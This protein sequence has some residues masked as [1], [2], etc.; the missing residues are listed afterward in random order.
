MN[1]ASPGAGGRTELFQVDLRGVVEILSQ[2]LYSSPRVFLRELLQ[3]ARDAVVARGAADAPGLIQVSVEDGAIVVADNGIGLDAGEM[4]ALL[5]TIGA[6][7]KRADLERAQQDFLGR[8]GIGLLSCFLI[9]DAVEVISRSAKTDHA[10]TVRWVGSSDG[11]YEITEAPEALREPGSRIIVRPRPEERAWATPRRLV[12]VARE[13]ARYL[14]TPVDVVDAAGVPVRVSTATAP[15]DLDA[16]TRARLC[17]ET[18][19]FDPLTTVRIDVPLLGVRG[20]AFVTP[21]ETA[22]ARRGGDVVHARGMLVAD[23]NTQ[24]APDWAYFARLIVD[25]GTL[26]L[27]ASR[28]SLQ[29]T[30]LVREA[31]AAVGEQIQR[32]VEE[33]ARSHPDTFRRFVEAHA[34][35]LRAMALTD[36]TMFAFMYDHLRFGTSRGERTLRQLVAGTDT[37]PPARVLHPV[38]FAPQFRALA[39]L[40]RHHDLVLIDACHVHEPQL[41]AA[42]DQSDVDVSVR[43][44]DL[45]AF[46][47]AAAPAADPGLVASIERLVASALPGH[48]AQVVDLGVESVAALELA[49]DDAWHPDSAASSGWGSV[50]GGIAARWEPA[51]PRL[52]LNVASPAVRALGGALPDD[53]AAHAVRALSVLGRLHTGQALSDDD[54]LLLGDSLSTLITA[55]TSTDVAGGRP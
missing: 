46:V 45:E 17:V 5:A 37:E 15:Q 34:V 16:E 3:N 11:T 21:E 43:H 1:Q 51:G 7:S 31:A 39:P 35:G 53:V 52:V 12:R 2:H 25:A 27:T 33:L 13:F 54:H 6:S 22:S 28:E 19:G 14:D 55:A 30:K 24:L 29:D 20:V 50:L 18:F 48:R 49:P 4:R 26:P 44:L 36:P 8:F 41:L 10:P 47:E 40:A 32:H 23:D 42:L 9:G 38:L